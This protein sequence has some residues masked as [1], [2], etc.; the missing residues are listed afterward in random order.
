[1]S[2]YESLLATIQ[3][4][5]QMKRREAAI[6]Y[7][8]LGW[9]VI[10]LIDKRPI[11]P[12]TTD[13]MP[14]AHALSIFFEPYGDTG[15]S[16]FNIGIR[17]GQAS[18][19]IGIDIDG[20]PGM[21]AFHELV[22][23]KEMPDTIRFWTP[24]AGL[25]YLFRYNQEIASK[26]IR[27]NGKEVI[28][29]LSDGTQTV[30]PPSIINDRVY[31]WSDCR[32]IA[33]YPIELFHRLQEKDPPPP[34]LRPQKADP[35]SNYNRAAAYLAKCDPAIS[36]QGGHNQTFKIAVRLCRGFQLTYHEALDL[37]VNLYNPTCQPPWSIEELEHKIDDALKVTSPYRN[38][39]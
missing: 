2:I 10:P 4:T 15:E 38:M 18:G 23:V 13:P 39:I 12:W 30:A 36:G 7:R 5:N 27:R 33:D 21:Q 37:M 32:T 8:G 6:H 34:T 16:A 35:H 22:N 24:N 3:Q 20:S 31:H 25:R 17:M 28:R 14:S 9:W 19:L 26:S 29:I 11:T 1:M